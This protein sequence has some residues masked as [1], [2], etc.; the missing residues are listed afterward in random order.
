LAPRRS[1][2]LAKHDGIFGPRCCFCLAA[3]AVALGQTARSAGS[4]ESTHHCVF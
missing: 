1:V 3:A 2:M 4:L